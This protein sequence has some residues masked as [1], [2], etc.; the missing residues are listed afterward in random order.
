MEVQEKF[1]TRV[2]WVVGRS[3]AAGQCADNVVFLVDKTGSVGIK[4]WAVSKQ[5]VVDVIQ[6]LGD[7]VNI[8]AISYS[9]DAHV[10]VPLGSSQDDASVQS[11][12]F[13]M[14]YDGS[15]ATTLFGMKKLRGAFEGVA[16]RSVAVIVS[17]GP[18]VR[19]G[20]PDPEAVAEAS[21]AKS[22]GLKII[23]I[24]ELLFVTLFVTCLIF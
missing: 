22:A 24:G 3:S 2:S 18:T 5:F 13:G 14:K 15:A 9:T 21:A 11:A 7:S 10:A 4:N 8:G 19:G 23:G 20:G 16:G 12:V 6:G 17:D 1:I